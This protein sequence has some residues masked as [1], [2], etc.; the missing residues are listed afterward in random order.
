MV[1][2]GEVLK[3]NIDKEYSLYEE[4]MIETVSPFIEEVTKKIMDGDSM[5]QFS[6]QDY[7]ILRRNDIARYLKRWAIRNDLSMET[8]IQEGSNGTIIASF[9]PKKELY[10]QSRS[11]R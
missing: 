1:T 10:F 6:S 8:K 4:R 7:H 2:L 11:T 3:Q 9:R 5:P